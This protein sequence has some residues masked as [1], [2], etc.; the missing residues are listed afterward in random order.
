MVGE[1]K[2][3]RDLVCILNQGVNHKD[4][5]VGDPVVCQPGN[6]AMSSKQPSNPD[7]GGFEAIDPWKSEYLV[8]RRRNLPHLG[9]P[10]A[11]YFVTFRCRSN[12]E[13][14]AQ[15]Q[16]MVIAAI[17]ECDQKSIDLDGAVVMPDHA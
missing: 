15:A 9:V 4:V 6:G 5:A 3:Q 12:L 14:I 2:S 8:V 16:D 7:S 13:L 1:R 17:L 11:T 10:G